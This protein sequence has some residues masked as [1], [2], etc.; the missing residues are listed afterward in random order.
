MN[1]DI[2]EG[3]ILS[4]VGPSGSGK[5]TLLKL[6][7]GLERIQ[8]GKMMLDGSDFASASLH[9][10]ANE[11]PFGF[12]FQDHVL[13]PNMSVEK[14]V[15]FGIGEKRAAEK[16]QIVRRLLE[17]VGLSGYAKRYPDTLSG[18]QKQRVALIR[19]LAR[20]PNTLLMDE[21]FASVDAPL[22]SQLIEDTRLNLKSES[23]SAI[24]VTHDLDEAMKMGDRV[25]VL[26]AGRFVQIDTPEQL[27]DNPLSVFVAKALP[28][29][30]VIE[31][32]IVG[33]HQVQTGL[34]V[35]QIDTSQI[36]FQIGRSVKLGF[37][38]RDVGL[39]TKGTSC[40]VLDIR[41]VSGRCL[42]L[43]RAVDTDERFSVQSNKFH[44]LSVG[45]SASIKFATT[46]PY[47][48]Y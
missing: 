22:R 17:Q 14:N 16:S 34:G 24:M 28:D 41:F 23:T 2:S 43:L 5:T 29:L 42:V 46:K 48:Y 21:P 3:E 32:S 33:Q 38:S 25:G 40:V 47:I 19:A 7:A 30:L 44:G 27:F 13:F 1:L 26:V 18:G 36:D 15:A 12:V 11:R 8:I 4:I 45:Q 20:R 31:G 39:D 6:I 35:L 9:P 10:P 37:R